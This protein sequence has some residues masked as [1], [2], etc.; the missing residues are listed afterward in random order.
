ME[1][2]AIDLAQ[3]FKIQWVKEFLS[4]GLRRLVRKDV[5]LNKELVKFFDWAQM[6]RY[7]MIT[8]YIREN[9]GT[10]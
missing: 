2:M 10:C 8:K 1:K 9:Y 7:D 4:P 3:P 5:F 6:D